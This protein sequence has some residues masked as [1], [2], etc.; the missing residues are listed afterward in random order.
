[1]Q[2]FIAAMLKVRQAFYAA[3]IRSLLR[4]KSV[5]QTILNIWVAPSVIKDKNVDGNGGAAAVKAKMYAEFIDDVETAFRESKEKARLVALSDGLRAQ[6][7]ESLLDNPMNMLPS[8]NHQLPTGDECGTYLA[9][10]VGGSTFRIALI[11]LSGRKNEGQEC[12]ILKRDSYKITSAVKQLKGVLFFDWMAERIGETLAG[13]EEGHDMASA[14]L[15]MGMSWSFPIEYVFCRPFG[16]A[17]QLTSPDKLPFEVDCFL[18]W[19]KGFLRLMVFSAK[20]LE[21]SFRIHV[22]KRVSMFN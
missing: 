9:L 18:G 3:I 4:T 16:L 2:P 1:M 15:S 21:I 10:D 6:F 11:E 14:P 20:I 17:G 7:G 22:R 19:V 8:Y 5:L 12:Q 13:H